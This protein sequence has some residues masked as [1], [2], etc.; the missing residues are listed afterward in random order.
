MT[1]QDFTI[2]LA[3]LEDLPAI[4]DIYNASIPGRLATADTEPVSV[5]QR[6]EWFD[7]HTLSRPIWVAVSEQVENEQQV[8]GWVSLEPFYGRPAYAQ[9][10]EV[11]LYLHPDAQGKGLGRTLLEFVLS[12][13]KSLDITHLVAYIFS[14]NAP[15]LGLFRKAGFEPW[16][17][18]PGIAKMDG[19]RYGLT[20]LGRVLSED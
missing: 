8:L 19:L 9:T 10:V 17:Q 20:I 18:L 2:R 13:A 14:H 1:A 7:R 16:G 6:Q 12:Q 3:R 11:S 5:E 15:S 4:V